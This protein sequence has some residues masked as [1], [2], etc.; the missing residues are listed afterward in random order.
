MR[1]TIDINDKL[2]RQVKNILGV[3]TKKDAVEYSL[4]FLIR[5]KQRERLRK[6]IGK[7]DLDLTLDELEKIR[8]EN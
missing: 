5:E 3:K 1:T 7:A 4:E 2:L 8:E 6:K